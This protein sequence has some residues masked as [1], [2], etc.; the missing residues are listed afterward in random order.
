[1][2]TNSFTTRRC[3]G[4]VRGIFR[5]QHVYPRLAPSRTIEGV[6]LV[7]GKCLV[8][9]LVPGWGDLACYWPRSAAAVVTSSTSAG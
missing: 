1:M 6:L 2:L 9:R 4:Q 5:R 8:R 3:K 7:T